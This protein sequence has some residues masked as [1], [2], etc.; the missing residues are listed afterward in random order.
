MRGICIKQ[1]VRVKFV[2][3]IWERILAWSPIK[4]DRGLS[5]DNPQTNC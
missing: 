2:K 1:I 4:K 5:P 3:G